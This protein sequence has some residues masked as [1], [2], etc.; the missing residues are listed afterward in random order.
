M[1]AQ[2]RMRATEKAFFGARTMAAQGM[3]YWRDTVELPRL[4]PIDGDPDTREFL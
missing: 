1:T 4:G 2:R 3:P